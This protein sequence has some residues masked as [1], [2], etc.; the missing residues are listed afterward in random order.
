MAQYQQNEFKQTQADKDSATTQKLS[1]LESGLNGK[2]NANALNTLT[3]KVNQVDGKIT[4]QVSKVNTLQTTVNNQTASISQHSQTLN[5]LS[6]QY[7]I[8]VQTGGVV[9]GIG[10]ASNNGMSDFAVR[11]DKFYIAP[12]TGGKGDTPFT[13]LTSPQVING[14]QVPAGTYIK[15]AFIANG[16][17]TMAKIADSIQSDNYVQGRSGWR[18]YK[19][20][21]LEINSSFGD[22]TR[23]QLNSRGLTGWYGNGQKAFE[24]GIFN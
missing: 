20:G 12:P 18:L 16:S 1:Q 19:N 14:V 10:L 24:L 13:V 11:A 17:I 3:T 5:G 23:I 9:A 15:N 4:A 22:G 21:E 7:T 6:A 2:A 8:K